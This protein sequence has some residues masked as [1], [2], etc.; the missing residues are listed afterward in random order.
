MK[1]TKKIKVSRPLIFA[2]L[3]AALIVSSCKP[4]ATHLTQNLENSRVPGQSLTR[5]PGESTQDIGQETAPVLPPTSVSEPTSNSIEPLP[6]QAPS[7]TLPPG[8]TPS[9]PVVILTPTVTSKSSTPQAATSTMAPTQTRTSTPTK[10]LTPTANGTFTP[11]P[12]VQTGWEGE[13]TAYVVQADGSIL[14]GILT[15]TLSGDDVSG[16]YEVQGSLMSLEGSFQWEGDQVSGSYAGF[17]G[18]GFF[19]WIIREAGTFAGN[20][21]NQRAFCGARAGLPQPAPCGYFD[22][23]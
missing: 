12:T 23:E 1:E 5:T 19:K 15:L 2:L 14:V 13:W 11:S 20:L 6:T 10:T 18:N 9:S 16:E 8:Q 17:S 4:K 22:P 7:V 21:D 3:L